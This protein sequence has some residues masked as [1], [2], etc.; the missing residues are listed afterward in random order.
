VVV[1]LG[2]DPQAL[3][4][5][6][7][8][9][10]PLSSPQPW[11]GH[12]SEARAVLSWVDGKLLKQHRHLPVV[13]AGSSLGAQAAALIALE[14][15]LQHSHE[16]QQQQQ[17][18]SP[19]LLPK[20]SGCLLFYP[21][22]SWSPSSS[23]P[24]GFNRLWAWWN[25]PGRGLATM[26]HHYTSAT[27]NTAEA[28]AAA[29]ATLAMLPPTLVI[30][31]ALDSVN[32]VRHSRDLATAHARDTA[33]AAAAAALAAGSSADSSAAGTASTTPASFAALA[34]VEVPRG[35]QGFELARDGAWA[36]A[37]Q[38]A[39]DWAAMLPTPTNL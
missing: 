3:S 34:V 33:A 39:L 4:N 30:H 8:P 22:A 19:V 13:V 14:S 7:S 26:P 6:S 38:G 25:G 36:A 11:L 37:L 24:L 5:L 9:P 17:Q 16:K 18:P 21:Q 29:V 15:D 1:R 20:V 2:T 12:L 27:A 10:S 23:S 31:G 32:P 35:R 28:E